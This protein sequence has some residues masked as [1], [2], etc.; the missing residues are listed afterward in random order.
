MELLRLPAVLQE[1]ADAL[2]RRV[3]VPRRLRPAARLDE[4][5]AE[6]ATQ[7]VL[8]GRAAGRAPL[9][10]G[11]QRLPTGKRATQSFGV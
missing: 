3:R 1:G 11:C 9:H 5:R 2:P 8:G 7:C 4:D 10:R 6:P